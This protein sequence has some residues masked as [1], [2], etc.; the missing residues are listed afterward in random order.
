VIQ[1]IKANWKWR[2]VNGEAV[3]VPN[4]TV[5]GF[6]IDPEGYFP[7]IYRGPNVR[8]AKNCWSL[9]S[10]LHECGYTLAEQFA[11]ELQEE[12]NIEADHTKT[13]IL[14]V[15]ENIAAVD[16]WHW[17]I[18]VMAVPVK[19]LSTMENKEPDKHPEI[20]K[21][22]YTEIAE[23]L[24][25]NWAPSLGPFIKENSLSIRNAIVDFL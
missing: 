11:V 25:L 12:L 2:T 17:V 18:T 7:L 21:V 3:P 13:R 20:R 22:H 10:G 4:V 19:T 5:S 9:P 23:L 16:N 24:K 15:Y 8:S 1:S 6:A 14:G